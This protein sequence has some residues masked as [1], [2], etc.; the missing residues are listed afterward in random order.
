MAAVMAPLSLG[1]AAQQSQKSP[2]LP[3]R[4]IDHVGITVPDLDAASRFLEQALGAV[5][6][7]DAITR[8]DPPKQGSAVEK[9]L[10]L[11]PGTKVTTMRMMRLAN[12]PGIELFEMN[13]STQQPPARPS[14]FGLQHVAVYVDDID[15]SLRRFVAAGGTILS[16]PTV[17]L[18]VEKGNGDKWAYER[19]PW[20]T[21]IELISYPGAQEYEET[22]K[23]RRWTP[24]P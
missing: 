12:G 24:A 5:P 21:V 3:T 4:G 1:L 19:A 8:S 6:L 18:G 7:Y 13:G 2:S 15:A 20:G 17:M 14:D 9:Q 10:D 16:G 22:A 11:A 23:L